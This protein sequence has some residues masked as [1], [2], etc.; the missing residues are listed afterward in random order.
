[1]LG[2]AGIAGVGGRFDA[3]WD[4]QRHETFDSQKEDRSTATG[5][6]TSDMMS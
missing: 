1:M 2:W 5:A 3:G 6:L 4:A